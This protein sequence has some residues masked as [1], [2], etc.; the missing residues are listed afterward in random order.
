MFERFLR[1]QIKVNGLLLLLPQK[2]P[3]RFFLK[4][5]ILSVQLLENSKL[6][7]HNIK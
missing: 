5:R 2:L 6:Y 4:L 1:K 7:F 3:G